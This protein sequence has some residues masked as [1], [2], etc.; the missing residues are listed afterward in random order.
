MQW[1]FLNPFDIEED[2]LVCLLSGASVPPDIS[3]DIETAEDRGRQAKDTFINDRLTKNANFF[4]PLTKEK[5]KTFADIG[6]MVLVKTTQNKTTECKQ[7]GNVAFKFLVNSQTHKLDLRELL[8]CTVMPVPSANSKPDGPLLK[9]DNSK[10][11][12]TLVKDTK[13]ASIPP[14]QT[15]RTLTTEMPSST[16]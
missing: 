2:G 12:N 3:K 13:D 7:Q 1:S 16:Q 6:K 4:A 10:G 15:P 11:F 8:Q 9:T 14:D 5:L